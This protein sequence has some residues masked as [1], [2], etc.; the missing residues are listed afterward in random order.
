MNTLLEGASRMPYPTDL[1]LVFE[2][3]G[4]RQRE[5][6]WLLTDLE[7]NH[8]PPSLS[9]RDGV[10]SSEARWLSGSELSE[11]VKE[12]DIQF[13]WGVLSG[14]RPGVAID[15]AALETY[16]CADGNR[17]LWEPGA[18]IQHPLADVEIVC[19]DSRATLL[20]SGDDD[21]TRRFRNFFPE[22]ID[23]NE[24]NRAVKRRRTRSH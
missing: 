24:H 15:L 19:W 9:Y 4:G 10:R 3:F 5:F 2:A 12:S 18:S 23:L 7:L 22:A 17:A 16:P 1:R 6:N 14:F 11:I 21:L 20:L 13:I 8:Y